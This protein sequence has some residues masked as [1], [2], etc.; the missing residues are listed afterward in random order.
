MDLL[1]QALMNAQKQRENPYQEAGQG[2]S[3]F[4]TSFINNDR[5]YGD[6]DPKDRIV[7]SLLTGLT[8]AVVQGFGAYQERE[9]RRS[10]TNDLM[11]LSGAYYGGEDLNPLVNSLQSQDAKDLVPMLQMEQA[12]NQRQLAQ[13]LAKEKAKRQTD[14]QYDMLGKTG[15]LMGQGEGGLT[16][17]KTP[18]ADGLADI[19]GQKTLAQE[20]AKSKVEQGLGPKPKD[21][22][23]REDKFR[24]ELFQRSGVD[25]LRTVDQSFKS[26]LQSY[27]DTSGASDLDFIYGV[28][29]TLDPTSVVR[30]GEQVLMQ[31]T[32]GIFGQLNSYLGQVK[33]KRKLEEETR[34]GLL[35]LAANRRDQLVNTYTGA[36]NEYKG[37]TDRAGG[38]FANVGVYGNF[39]P[40]NKLLEALQKAG[41]TTG[42][43]SPKMFRI[44]DKQTNEIIIVP[45]TELGK[46][47][48]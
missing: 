11:G 25:A 4:G 38:N 20:L 6:D 28:A 46:Y 18:L 35:D 10:L 9:R 41:S 43:P 32:D 24:N 40:S 34:R 8:G 2:L 15:M 44:R 19:E 3:S 45:E 21:I 39:E 12:S 37:L 26:M 30:E 31:R 1:T 5:Q 27:S 13:E 22:V 23:D 42:S 47:Q 33:G 7:A 14:F 17:T 29:K 48:Q 16:F 36:V